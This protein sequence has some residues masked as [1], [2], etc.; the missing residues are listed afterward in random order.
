MLA[1]LYICC[2]SLIKDDVNKTL[3]P[4]EDLPTEKSH[5]CCPCV[6]KLRAQIAEMELFS[7]PDYVKKFK[8]DMKAKEAKTKT[9]EEKVAEL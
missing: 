1:I 7:D 4:F 6:Y 3:Q 9:Y 8:A 5:K 2:E